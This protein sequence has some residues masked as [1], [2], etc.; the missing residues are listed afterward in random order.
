MFL[1]LKRKIGILIIA[2]FCGLVC[3]IQ[4]EEKSSEK[5]APP[6]KSGDVI[7]FIVVG[8]THASPSNWGNVPLIIKKINQLDPQPDFVMFIGDI[9]GADS[10]KNAFKEIVAFEKLCQQLYSPYYYTL[11]NHEGIKVNLKRCSWEEMLKVYNMKERW[12]S[13]DIGDFHICVLDG[14]ISLNSKGYLAKGTPKRPIVDPSNT[15]TAIFKKEQEWFLN[16]LK[17]T[18]KKVIAFIHQAIGFYQEDNQHWIDINNLK[19]WPEGNFFERTF[20]DNRYKIVGVFEGHKHKA[21]WKKRNGV[22][23]HQ[24]GASFGRKGGQ[25]AQVFIDPYLSTFY[26]KAW[27]QSEYHDK[28]FRLQ[29]T[30]G[31]PGVMKRYMIQ[32]GGKQY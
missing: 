22:I 2:L 27:P 18:D 31:D 8:D 26:V 15:P 11:G 17:T 5:H 16:D 21:L 30:Y 29:Q 9:A 12:Y 19:F 1:S 32:R 28:G 23:Y 10:N 6:I 3:Q 24:I 7:N 25:F 13:F 14:W 20:E 4:A